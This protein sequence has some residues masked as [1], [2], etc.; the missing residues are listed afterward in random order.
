MSQ[1]YINDYNHTIQR[2]DEEKME[3]TYSYKGANNYFLNVYKTI[4][5]E[6]IELLS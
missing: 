3:A 2:G 5:A 4:G 6:K 1:I